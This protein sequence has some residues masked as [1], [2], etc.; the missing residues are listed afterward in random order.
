MFVENGHNRYYLNS[1][2]KENKHQAPEA[3]NTYNSIVKLRWIQL[4]VPKIRKELQKTGSSL[5]QLQN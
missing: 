4:V 3:K 2:A 1:I 5:Q